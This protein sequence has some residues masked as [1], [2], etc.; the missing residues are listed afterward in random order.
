MDS[1]FWWFVAFTYFGVAISM[2]DSIIEVSLGK[3]RWILA[4]FFFLFLIFFTVKVVVGSVYPEPTVSWTEGN[5]PGGTDIH[6][7]I[8]Q[9]GW[10]DLEVVIHNNTSTDLKDM[11]VAFRVDEGVADFK[12]IGGPKCELIDSDRPSEPTARG[13]DGVQR[14]MHQ[15]FSI[16]GTY[17]LLCDK[18]PGG[19]RV[20]MMMAIVH[21]RA[22]IPG[23]VGLKT[24]PRWVVF[25]FSYRAA[26]PRAYNW[27]SRVNPTAS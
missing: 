2:G 22:A 1:F 4:S 10:F 9:D 17:R 12:I 6:G 15:D 16:H 13:E 7:L 20:K 23:T 27:N 19:T 24:M 8:W 18:V 25:H 21:P 3:F 5:Y 11:D 26:V 14:L